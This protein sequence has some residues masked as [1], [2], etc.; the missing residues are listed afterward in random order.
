LFLVEIIDMGIPDSNPVW[1]LEELV[2]NTVE[3]NEEKRVIPTSNSSTH[4]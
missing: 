2:A 1:T 4:T 3:P